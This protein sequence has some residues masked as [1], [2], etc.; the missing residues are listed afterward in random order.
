MKV[1]VTGG[2][3]HSSAQDMPIEMQMGLCMA[4]HME[5]RG[6]RWLLA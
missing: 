1:D 2:S 4:M 5:M 6:N 3:I